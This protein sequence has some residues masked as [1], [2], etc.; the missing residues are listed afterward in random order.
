MSFAALLRGPRAADVGARLP[1]RRQYKYEKRQVEA[2]IEHGE[3]AA[4]FIQ[5]VYGQE[6]A[7]LL[8]NKL[9]AR[10]NGSQPSF[11]RHPEIVDLDDSAPSEDDAD[12]G[13]CLPYGC[14]RRFMV[15][16][17][18]IQPTRAK[19]MQ[20]LRSLKFYVQRK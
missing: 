17:L 4:T 15:E 10:G 14:W 9:A 19:K 13:R 1:A 5:S 20:L 11:A 8:L 7:T 18:A 6:Q 16:E 12:K 3:R 2:N